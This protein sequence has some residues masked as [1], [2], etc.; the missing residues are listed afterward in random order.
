MNENKVNSQAIDQQELIIL[1]N[2]YKLSSVIDYH[3][4]HIVDELK[5][6]TN[7]FFNLGFHLFK[8]KESWN[9]DLLKKDFYKFCEENFLLKT[10]SIKNFI[11][12]YK[13]FRSKDDEDEIDERFENFSFTALVELLPIADDKDFAKEFKKLSTREIREIVSLNKDDS[14]KG[15][16]N[17]VYLLIR[18]LLRKNDVDCILSGDK[19]ED[20]DI[21]FEISAKDSDSSVELRFSLDDG[22]D[23]YGNAED[24]I[25]CLRSVSYIAQFDFWIKSFSIHD[26]ADVVDVLS[27][28]IKKYASLHIEEK[29]DEKQKTK[30]V[31]T[32]A[33]KALNLKKK[34]IIPYAKNQD[35]FKRSVIKIDELGC[36]IFALEGCKYI[37]GIKY[38]S[39]Y[40]KREVF[41][42]VDTSL[43]RLNDWAINDLMLKD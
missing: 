40:S 4:E 41:D 26:V 17:Q 36:E 10:T 25:F 32:G 42:I 16:L 9:D 14:S 33:A 18:D 11:N 5:D 7:H 37:F 24:N 39:E 1:E 21:F 6:L 28:S 38:I 29:K 20:S 12:V 27:E 19:D 43:S 15:F 30:F 2:N 13:T 3:C 22:C 31:P 34:D 35:N 23:Y 8:L